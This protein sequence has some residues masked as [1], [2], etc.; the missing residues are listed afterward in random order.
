MMAMT[1]QDVF[2]R[3]TTYCTLNTEKTSQGIPDRQNN[4]ILGQ[5]QT[6]ILPL[7]AQIEI[8]DVYFDS[9]SANVLDVILYAV[10]RRTFKT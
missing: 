1:P 7:F 9:C 10:S 8:P 5:I 4:E 6:I 2:Q 3:R